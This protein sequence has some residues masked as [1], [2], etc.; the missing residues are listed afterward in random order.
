LIQICISATKLH[1]IYIKGKPILYQNF[2]KNEAEKAAVCGFG[3]II[4]LWKNMAPTAKNLA[5]QE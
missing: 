1:S 2:G 3:N 5:T 4:M